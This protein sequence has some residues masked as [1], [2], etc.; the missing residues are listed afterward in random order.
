MT[1]VEDLKLREFEIESID[2]TKGASFVVIAPPGTGK[3]TFMMNVMYY[4]KHRYPTAKLF[5]GEEDGYKEYCK[6]FPKLFVNNEWDEEEAERFKIRQKTCQYEN[7]KTDVANNSI[8]MIDDAVEEDKTYRRPFFSA[9]Y[10][11]YSR[12]G[13]NIIL[14]GTQQARDFPTPIRSNASYVV[15][16]QCD[17][18]LQLEKMYKMF[19][20]KFGSFKRF[21]EVLNFIAAKKYEF[22]VIHRASESNKLEDCVFWYTTKPIRSDWKFG[23][24]EYH[25]WS[26]TRYNENFNEVDDMDTKPKLQ[27]K[28]KI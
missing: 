26:K 14:L 18:I 4:N 16:G 8:I 9:L 5:I 13:N 21:C 6:I 10:K 24:K 11:K 28:N 23:C 20:G 7:H 19:G 22:L 3:T 25:A 2:H 27:T 17:D 15:I 1:S 12:H